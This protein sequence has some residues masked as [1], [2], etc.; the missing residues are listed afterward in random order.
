MYLKYVS[1]YLGEKLYIYGSK[2]L[3]L[4]VYMRLEVWLGLRLESNLEVGLKR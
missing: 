1:K 2:L 3:S 4:S